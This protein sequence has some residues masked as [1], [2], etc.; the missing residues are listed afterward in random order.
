MRNDELHLDDITPPRPEVTA[1]NGSDDRGSSCSPSNDMRYGNVLAMTQPE[2]ETS[3]RSSVLPTPP[4]PTLALD[5]MQLSAAP[6]IVKKR[7]TEDGVGVTGARAVPC[8]AARFEDEWWLAPVRMSAFQ[9]PLHPMQLGAIVL[10]LALIALYFFA[11]LPG[12]VR[13]DKNVMAGVSCA[14]VSVSFLTVI[15]SQYITS[16][17]DCGDYAD[18]GAMCTY[19]NRKTHHASKHCKTCNKCIGGFDHHC[20]WL[21]VCIGQRN[22]KAFLVYVTSAAFG[23]GTLAGVS[24]AFLVT[25]WDDMGSIS[26]YGGAG[27]T[28]AQSTGHF[29]RV[30]GIA[31]AVLSFSA[32][33][34]IMQLLLFHVRLIWLGV[35]TYEYAIFHN[36]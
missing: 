23:T 12:L 2:N 8:I 5:Q 13:L 17:V 19:C 1:Q 33:G 10:T 29:H 25:C 16:I 11:V 21:N 20:K 6:P 22:Y 26:T 3:K 14:L 31:L 4:P 24:V 35:T 30:C 7:S 9:L 27:S 36:V 15:V 28:S 18:Q 32:W 34:P